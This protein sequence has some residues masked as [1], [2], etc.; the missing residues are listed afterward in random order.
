METLD[1]RV[2]HLVM[3]LSTKSNVSFQTARAF[4]IILPASLSGRYLHVASEYEQQS[5]TE[6]KTIYILSFTIYSTLAHVASKTL[7]FHKSG[8]AM[9]DYQNVTKTLLLTE[10]QKQALTD[11]LPHLK[12]TQQF[13]TSYVIIQCSCHYFTPQMIGCSPM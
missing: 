10:T 12:H 7:S 11:C 3:Y 6:L 8:L 9:R 2:L 5:T 1:N 4:A 13:V